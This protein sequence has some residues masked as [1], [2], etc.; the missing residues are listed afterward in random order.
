MF[1]AAI[2]RINSI[3]EAPPQTLDMKIF[4]DAGGKADNRRVW[5]GLAVIGTSEIKWM[6]DVLDDIHKS[7]KISSKELKGRELSI[8]EIKSTGRMIREQD[9]R[10]LFW[11]NWIEC[12]NEENAQKF[13]R[14]LENAF[15]SMRSNCTRLD[16][17]SI[18][19]W[20][21]SQASFFS[22]LK[23]INKHKVLSINE[24][25]Q[26]VISEIKKCKLGHQLKSVEIVIDNENFQNE[27]D[28]GV[29]FKHIISAG[30]QSAGMH[31]TLTGKAL[32]EHAQEGAVNVNVTGKSEDVVG[33]RFVDILLQAVLRK[34]MPIRRTNIKKGH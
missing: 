18:D 29:L 2:G 34:V 16:K 17:D 10:I 4:I 13:A 11:A 12:W 21:K 14:E 28:C 5:G 25:L 8:E 19:A 9:R 3:I 27:K 1:Q 22:K 24:L 31:Y 33:I 6:K 7:N 23:P 30:L 26:W 15:S 32:K 20:Y